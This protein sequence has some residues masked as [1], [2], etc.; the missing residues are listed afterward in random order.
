MAGCTAFAAGWIAFFF[1]QPG[2]VTTYFPLSFS[3][4]PL[5]QG[6][7]QLCVRTHAQLLLPNPSLPALRGEIYKKIKEAKPKN[8]NF[9]F[10]TQ[11]V[12]PLKEKGDEPG[13][14]YRSSQ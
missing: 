1:S 12:S 10:R 6:V 11:Q 14:F 8:A 13:T 9:S 5:R 3:S 2:P 4:Q 7:S